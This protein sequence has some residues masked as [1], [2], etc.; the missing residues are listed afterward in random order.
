MYSDTLFIT[1]LGSSHVMYLGCWEQSLIRFSDQSES[2][3][4][5]NA[6]SNI[7]PDMMSSFCGLVLNPESRPQLVGEL[8]CGTG[9]RNLTISSQI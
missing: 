2:E 7:A 9:E 8:L 6:T 5:A 4:L 3:F 1:S